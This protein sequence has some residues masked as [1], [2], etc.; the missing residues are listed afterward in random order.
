MFGFG[1]KSA[2]GSQAAGGTS[3]EPSKASA[4]ASS[5]ADIPED[6]F[7]VMPEQYVPKGARSGSSGRAFGK[8]TLFLAGGA[9]LALV[10]FGVAL[11]AV[12][13]SEPEAV[14]LPAATAPG[15]SATPGEQTSEN[16]ETEVP[17]AAEDAALASDAVIRGQAVDAEGMLTGSIAATIPP[18]VS[19]QYGS[20]IGVTVLSE[21]DFSL[22][23]EGTV[24]GGLYSVYPAGIT[25]SEP[26][27]VEL[28]V[29]DIPASY[30]PADTY[31]A[32][33]RGVRWQEF[34]D[35]QVTAGGYAFLLERVPNGPIAVI[36]NPQE[37]A[38]VEELLFTR[39]TPTVDTDVDG[40]TDA[41]EALFGTSAASADSDGDSYLDLEEIQNGYS[42]LAAGAT[43]SESGLFA[44]YTNATYGYQAAYPARWLADS[45][46]QT[47]KQVLFISDTEE[48]FE[49]LIVE[50]PLNTPIA[51]WFR[52][53]SPSLANAELDVAVISGVPAVWS[54]DGLTLYVSSNG[55]IYILTYNN[56]TSDEINWPNI[57]RHFHENFVLGA[58]NVSGSSD[59]TEEGGASGE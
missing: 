58:T 31:P 17:G 19:G 51:D 16:A 18:T 14:P 2:P 55:L 22:P 29:A 52:A 7:T 28:S 46:D 59:G 44:M 20:G 45:L 24:L 23:E 40:L 37:E 50:N 42:P 56:G 25:F 39:A 38:A 54:P 53:Q 35:Y 12:F 49:I 27:S 33:L 43:L 4:Q 10:V 41:E 6:K 30:D 9:L 57:F 34:P 1:K 21:E 47:N 32:Y 48:F 5:V 15:G 3:K 8:K 26:L 11:Y 36:W 13:L